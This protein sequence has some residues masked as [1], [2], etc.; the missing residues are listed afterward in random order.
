MANKAT[1]IG[2]NIDINV[3]NLFCKLLREHVV[4]VII[5]LNCNY[6]STP[7]L[8]MLLLCQYVTTEIFKYTFL[9]S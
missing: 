6:A 8:M 7:Q 4:F 2:S 5:V 9:Y 3:K 1:T